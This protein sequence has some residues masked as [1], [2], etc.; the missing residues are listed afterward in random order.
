MEKKITNILSVSNKI[1]LIGSNSMSK[2]KYSTDYDLQEHITITKLSQYST[3]VKKI[4]HIFKSFVNDKKIYIVDFKSGHFNTLPVRWNYDE[5]MNGYK[6]IDNI[7]INLIDTLQLEN[8]TIKIDIV[9]FINDSFVEFSCNYYFNKTKTNVNDI[10]KSLLLD[11][12][13]YYHSKKFMK[14]LKRLLSYRSIKNEN[15]DDIVLFLNSDAGKLYQFQHKVDVLLFVLEEKV[16]FDVKSVTVAT[17]K[18]IKSIPELYKINISSKD[19]IK[20]LHEIKNKLNDDINTLVI[21]FL[22]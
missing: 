6:N 16:K 8:N 5:I 14:M 7:V 11:V 3:Y 22:K 1:E 4:Q 17:N 21:E 12:N 2:I 10:Y 18:L 15:V 20:M 19:S 13:K 9:A